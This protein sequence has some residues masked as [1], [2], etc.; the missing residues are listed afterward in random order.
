MLNNSINQWKGSTTV[1]FLVKKLERLIATT[2]FK[3]FKV[4]LLSFCW[5]LKV[6]ASNIV[7]GTQQAKKQMAIIFV[8]C[9]NF[10]FV[11]PA[12]FSPNPT[13]VF[14]FTGGT[15]VLIFAYFALF[16]PLCNYHQLLAFVY[17]II[18]FIQSVRFGGLIYY[19]ITFCINLYLQKHVVDVPLTEAFLPTGY[20]GHPPDNI[21]SNDNAP[22]TPP[23]SSSEPTARNVPTE[24]QAHL[25]NTKTAATNTLPLP[26]ITPG[27]TTSVKVTTCAKG[28]VI[29]L[30]N[31]AWQ[32]VQI[33]DSGQAI[34]PPL[35]AI[36][37]SV[38]TGIL[39]SERPICPSVAVP[40]VIHAEP[41]TSAVGTQPPVS[42]AKTCPNCWSN[43]TPIVTTELTT[44][45]ASGS[46]TTWGMDHHQCYTGRIY[47]SGLYEKGTVFIS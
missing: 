14:L 19:I 27:M 7:F 46:R 42:I 36:V 39:Y 43:S 3:A 31:P 1:I 6:W 41:V 22:A 10:L 30:A 21:P 16:L 40:V 33:I 4:T 29:A 44:T 35:R 26:K 13:A 45:N 8:I 5:F 9:L 2:W 17:L 34:N 47:R 20:F 23:K 32:F 18:S 24:P 37:E 11:V 25:V 15:F 12:L 38:P 28:G